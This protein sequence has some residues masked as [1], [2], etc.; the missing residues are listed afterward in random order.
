MHLWRDLTVVRR[1]L[2]LHWDVFFGSGVDT[3]KASGRGRITLHIIDL[4]NVTKEPVPDKSFFFLVPCH[5]FY[6]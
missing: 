2:P 1:V 5:A 4:R 3:Y 6:R